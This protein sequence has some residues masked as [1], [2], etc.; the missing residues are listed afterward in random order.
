[1]RNPGAHRGQH[2]FSLVEILVALLI[3]VIVMAVAFH[4][5][6]DVQTHMETESSGIES[7]QAARATADE[8]SRALQ[9]VGYGIDRSVTGNPAVWQKALVYGGPHAIAYNADIDP[10][11]GAMTDGDTITLPN[12]S[13]YRGEIAARDIRGA[14]T[15]FYTLDANGDGRIDDT[16]RTAAAAG[17]HNPAAETPV[18]LDFAIFRQVHGSDAANPV[19]RRTPLTAYLFT[20]ATASSVYPNGTTP[21]PL[22]AYW[23][24][25]DVNGN[26]LLDETECVVA[27]CPP[28][29][30]RAPQLYLWADSDFDGQLS[31]T[32]KAAYQTLP[33]GD[34]GW[35]ANPLASSG[36]YRSTTLS[37]A[38]IGG[39]WAA[40]QVKVQN[41]TG[42]AKGQIIEIGSG[43]N[44]EKFMIDGVDMT[45]TPHSLTVSSESLTGHS[46]GEPVKIHPDTL[47]RMV[48]TVEITIDAIGPEK[49]IDQARVSV[50][51]G[52]AGRAGTRG[53]DYPV[54]NYRRRVELPNLRTEPLTRTIGSATVVACPITIEPKCVGGTS[55]TTATI[56]APGATPAPLSFLV[57]DGS[58]QPKSNVRV[59]FASAS[60]SVGVLTSISALSD[61]NGIA[62]TYYRPA[63]P[64]GTDTV[65][66]TAYC[67]TS[68]GGAQQQTSTVTVKISTLT[69]RPAASCLTT[70]TPRT[71][72]SSTTVPIE[73]R[74]SAGVIV[75]NVGVDLTAAF[76]ASVMPAPANFTTVAAELVVNG[77]VVARTD[78]ATGSLN[79]VGNTG[80]T[81]TLTPELRLTRDTAGNGARIFLT[82]RASTTT[83]PITAAEVY[84]SLTF[85]KLALRSVPAGCVSYAP[86]AI[87]PNS[88]PPRVE[89]VLTIG[90]QPVANQAVVFTKTDSSGSGASSD[91]IPPSG[92]ITDAS[93]VA[94]VSVQTTPGATI[95]P[96]NPLRTT[97]DAMIT[98]GSTACPT[99]N[100]IA[101]D[102]P[103]GFRF[104]GDVGGCDVDVVQASVMRVTSTNDL[105]LAVQ[106]LNLPGECPVRI[107]GVTFSVYTTTGKLDTQY[108]ISS[109]RGG[110]IATRATPT[111]T[112]SV[113]LY[114]TTCPTRAGNLA[115][116]ASWTF[117]QT[118]VCNKPPE[119]PGPVLP[120][121]YFI[122]D[123][124]TFS[125]QIAGLLVPRRLDVAITYECA[126]ACSGGTQVTK[127]FV[128]KTP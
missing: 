45:S 86:C 44:A 63:G 57:K 115:N 19:A 11:V 108:S 82:A 42:F 9:H 72:A 120:Q 25:E 13:T 77:S 81:G 12:G 14:E 67:V 5:L 96:A 97:V 112:N 27:P 104:E 46:I 56:L 58:G 22:F 53:L 95:D 28:S 78:P 48:R 4:F 84:A 85:H 62:T 33:A 125:R 119:P 74:D 40:N 80:S 1:M 59:T 110:S 15:Y 89:A 93:G 65:T 71:P 10:L 18:P 7:Q 105:A 26:N 20:N 98:G 76:D 101:A 23:L 118:S 24:S 111:A 39:S 113:A 52:R 90:G 122:F 103:V 79:Y 8:L 99:G 29:S 124:V 88:Q 47:L 69:V 100:I 92:W 37:Q 36:Q 30:A 60:S 127:T 38:V 6:V 83:C 16:D 55:S 51:P 107:K 64:A 21:S 50:V 17:S 117:A 41:A 66:A 49:V 35:S 91:L 114:A 87:P 68:S 109:I 34:P 32:E 116:G 54:R 61:R 31:E 94:S 2:G 73:V 70:I 126:G 75:P 3:L 123:R 121:Q 43:A 106:N 102:P 128:L